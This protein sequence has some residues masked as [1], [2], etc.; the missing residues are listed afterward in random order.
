MD[1]AGGWCVG[2]IRI[3]RKNA[4][5]PPP[6]P[7]SY[8]ESPVL[9]AQLD[10]ASVSE[11]EGLGFESQQA[12]LSEGSA[13]LDPRF[14]W[15]DQKVSPDATRVSRDKRDRHSVSA[16]LGL[17]SAF[18]PTQFPDRVGQSG[19]HFLMVRSVT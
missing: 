13:W 18:R 5:C 6:L 19:S 3:F 14:L 8:N 2:A 9:V 15:R 11:A 12:R 10:R 7:A 17:A 4:G 1:F 16:I